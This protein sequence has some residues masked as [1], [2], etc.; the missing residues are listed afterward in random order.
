MANRSRSEKSTAAVS[1]KEVRPWTS[2]LMGRTGDLLVQPV[3][4]RHQLCRWLGPS[5][6]VAVVGR[7]ELDGSLPGDVDFR[8]VSVT[9]SLFDDYVDGVGKEV[10]DLL[11]EAGYRAVGF[12]E[13]LEVVVANAVRFGFQFV[14]CEAVL[15]G[16]EVAELTDGRERDG[17]H[18]RLAAGADVDEVHAL[19]LA[20][21]AEVDL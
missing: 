9:R 4:E 21:F 17:P 1:R 20:G 6:Q 11:G 14:E 19:L 12:H 2:S 18:V 7:E 16:A 5:V 13:D 15:R 3:E 10:A 8:Q